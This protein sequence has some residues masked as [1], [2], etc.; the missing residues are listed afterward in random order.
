MHTLLTFLADPEIGLFL[1]TAI[2][3][4]ILFAVLFLISE[5]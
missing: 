5:H 1:G 4:G 2:V 3:L